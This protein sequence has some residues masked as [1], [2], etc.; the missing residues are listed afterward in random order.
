VASESHFSSLL[1]ELHY[2]VVKVK[3]KGAYN[4]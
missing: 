1:A 4:C 3:G 2:V